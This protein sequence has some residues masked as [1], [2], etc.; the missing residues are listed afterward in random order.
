MINK[1]FN[2]SDADEFDKL[3]I[4]MDQEL[5]IQQVFASIAFATIGCNSGMT[6]ASFNRCCRCL[7]REVLSSNRCNHWLKK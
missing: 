7:Q 3:A 4:Q 5:G 1:Q 6:E 2:N